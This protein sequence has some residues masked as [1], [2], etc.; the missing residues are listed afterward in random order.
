[1]SDPITRKEQYYAK[2]AGE[3]VEVPKPI[4]REEQYLAKI[5]EGGGGG[6]LEF[7]E[8]HLD[9]ETFIA[10][11]TWQ[12]AFDALA[13]GKLI[14]YKFAV[15]SPEEEI[16]TAGMVILSSAEKSFE[17]NKYYLSG[18]TSSYLGTAESMVLIASSPNDYLSF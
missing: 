17:D 7:V 9:P 8:L 10:D 4:T 1:M 12:Q 3:N 15:N 18:V 11:M 14:I 16:L 6:G 5:A 2:M 13:S